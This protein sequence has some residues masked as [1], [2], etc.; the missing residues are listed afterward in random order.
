M[1]YIILG[2]N[3]FIGKGLSK[4]FK[5]KKVNFTKFKEIP[6]YESKLIKNND[7]II[8]CLGKNTD[9]KTDI[10]LINFIKFLRSNKHKILWIQ[11]S[12]PLVYDQK[13]KLK[14]IK[15]D[16]K[17]V[18]FNKYASSKLKFDNFLKSQKS[19][20][21]SYLILRVSTVYDK[22]MKSKVFQK[23]KIIHKS[24]LYSVTLNPKVIVNYIR[25]NELIDYIYQLSINKKSWNKIILISQYI[26]LINLLGMDV[27]KRSF[28][29]KLFFKIKGFLIP[30]F[31]EQVLFLIN[32]KKIEN[33]FLKKFIKIEDK[34]DSKQKIIRFLNL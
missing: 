9:N 24:F 10:Q 26:K 4:F 19:L 5:K 17:E 32:E 27:K 15:E 7:V 2:S 21:F 22:N 20:S 33:S 18:P 16:T 31:S 34:I 6:R 23:L 14:K 11:L 12:T 25:L 29:N 1:R 3:G 30:F 13:T 8:N 28:L